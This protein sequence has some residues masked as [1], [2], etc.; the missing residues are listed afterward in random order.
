MADDTIDL[1]AMTPDRARGVADYY[2][3]LWNADW[4]AVIDHLGAATGLTRIEAMSF[5]ALMTIN[6]L[7]NSNYELG[8]MQKKILSHAVK[9]LDDEQDILGG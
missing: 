6:S 3:K 1:D 7:A 8:G 5:Y 4:G 2:I 9:E